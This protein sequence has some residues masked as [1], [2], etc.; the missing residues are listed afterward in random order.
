MCIFSHGDLYPKA[1][2]LKVLFYLAIC[3]IDFSLIPIFPH[4]LITNRSELQFINMR[5]EILKDGELHT[6]VNSI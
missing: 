2:L 1:P 6:G 5:M 3:F 4:F